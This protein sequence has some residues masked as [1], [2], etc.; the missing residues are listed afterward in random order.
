MNVGNGFGL[1]LLTN[2][3][4]S[5]LSFR[6]EMAHP[7]LSMATRGFGSQIDG[8]GGGGGGKIEDRNI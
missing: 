1:Q 5:L 7:R 8:R 6:R 2:S 4:K 3:S